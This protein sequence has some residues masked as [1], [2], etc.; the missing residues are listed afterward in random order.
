MHDNYEVQ[1]WQI[2]LIYIAYM[3]GACIL[4]IFG[5]RLLPTINKTAI[6]WSVTLR[7]F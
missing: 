5:L 3:L 4:N 6:I 7:E 1:R 2:F